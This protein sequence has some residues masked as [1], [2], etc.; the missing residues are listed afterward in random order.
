[1][2]ITANNSAGTHFVVLIEG[3]DGD[4][5]MHDPIYGH[6]LDFDDYYSTSQIFEAVTFR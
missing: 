2:G 3:D 4:Y 1:V 6:D 5:K